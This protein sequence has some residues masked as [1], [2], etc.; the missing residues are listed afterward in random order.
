M[1]EQLKKWILGLAR[2]RDEEWLD[3]AAQDD[4]FLLDAIE[5]YR[6]FPEGRHADR[7]KK[8]RQKLRSRSREP[9]SFRWGRVAAA[10]V[11][12]VVAGG[13]IW[14]VASTDFGTDLA[15]RETAPLEEEADDPVAFE[16]VPRAEEERDLAAPP[17]QKARQVQPSL[18]ETAEEPEL[19]A[20]GHG[21]VIED[22]EAIPADENP[23]PQE[24]E[25]PVSTEA[26]PVIAAMPAD[27]PEAD[28]REEVQSF[29]AESEGRAERLAE[30]RKALSP[31]PPEALTLA[32]MPSPSKRKEYQAISPEQGQPVPRGGYTRLEAYISRQK[33]YPEAAKEVG[34][35]GV[36]RLAFSIDSLG[37]P[38][39]FEVLDSLGYG[40]EA[41]AIRLLREG[42]KWIV[43][44]GEWGGRVEY[45]LSFGKKE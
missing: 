4:P 9:R 8:I 45:E 35:T 27:Q 7:L 38:F 33:Q 28:T 15:Q 44:G 21:D 34:K 39:N 40:C 26:P 20:D 22:R 12:L 14:W 31:P 23:I 13:S 5:G 29:A 1:M 42:P 16:P 19:T 25:K 32:D 24:E 10:V 3:R 17:E 6:S 43:P 18:P 2:R 11:L 37:R 36:V 30:T 41:E